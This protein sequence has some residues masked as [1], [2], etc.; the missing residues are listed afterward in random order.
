MVLLKEKESNREDIRMCLLK[1]N[2]ILFG[3]I[4]LN[5]IELN[6]DYKAIMAEIETS[7]CLIYCLANLN[8]SLFI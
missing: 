1:C 6:N 8:G 2:F 4:L 5:K 3:F 7:K